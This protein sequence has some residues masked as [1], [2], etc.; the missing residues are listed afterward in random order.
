MLISPEKL[1]QFGARHSA[2]GEGT[3]Q[4]ERSVLPRALRWVGGATYRRAKP[5][6]ALALVVLAVAGYGLTQLVVN[7]NPIKWFGPG[8]PIR[9]ADEVLNRHFGGTHEAYFVLSA[10]EEKYEPKQFLAGLNTQA[11]Q[12]A[13]ALKAE[14][15]QAPQAFADLQALAAPASERASSREAALADLA[16]QVQAKADQSED[17]VWE[18][19]GLFVDGQQQQS[20]VFKDPAALRYI[21]QLQ[22]EMAR[23]HVVGKSNSLPDIVKTVHR[24]LLL[25]EQA[26]FRIP[27]SRGAVAQSLLSFQNSHRPADLWHFVTPDFRSTNIWIQLKSG[28]NQDMVQLV[29]A[30]E[31]YMAANPPPGNLRGEW[32]GLTFLNVAWQDKMVSGMA[33]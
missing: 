12:R 1:E 26:Q 18:Q 30:L 7:D 29:K 3:Q 22:T 25:G 8:H 23:T 17:E 10:V 2:E 4:A 31:T 32:F 20:E 13:E 24:D 6:L 11:Q 33:Q 14:Y 27:D 28:D 15:P 5:L 21:E 16:R 9:V 19:V